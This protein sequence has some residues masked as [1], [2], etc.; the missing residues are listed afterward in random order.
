MTPTDGPGEGD[1]PAIDPR[2]RQRR[3]AIR[4]SEGR[5]RLTWVVAVAVVGVVAVAGWG[6]LHT[7]WFSA[8]VVTVDGAHPHTS[9]A[10]IVA[11]ARLDGHGFL[12]KPYEPN[13]LLK[14]VRA[15]LDGGPESILLG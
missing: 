12:A 3:V 13:T 11:A 9:S 4:R 8:Q 1:P 10:A 15:C 7:G 2:I 5:R 14:L 6:L